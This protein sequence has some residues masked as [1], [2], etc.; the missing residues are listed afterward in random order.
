MALSL[1]E[2][3]DS[4][5]N[6]FEQYKSILNRADADKKELTADDRGN[7]DRLDTQIDA[8]SAEIDTENSDQ[9]R[10][11][12]ATAFEA[13]LRGDIGRQTESLA[14]GS[15]PGVSLPESSLKL[16]RP[17]MFGGVQ[18]EL[19]KFGS[20][21][22]EALRMSADYR[23][24]YMNYLAT[25]ER[26]GLQ[27]GVDTK[28]G[29]LA[30]P[31][32]VAE[33]IKFLDNMVFMRGICR[34][35][36]TPGTV[37]LGVPTWDTDPNDC[38][39]TAEVPASAITEDDAARIG[40]REL[41]PHLLTKL[42]K[43]GMVLLNSNTL[44]SVESLLA[45]RLAY[46]FA[47]TEEQAFL[48]GTGIQQPLGVFTAS[49]S[50]IATTRDTTAAATT[51]FTMDELISTLYSLKA[52][53]QARSTWIFHRDTVQRIRKF[54]TGDSQYLWQ[55]SVV[56][57]QPDLV[58]NRPYVMSEY[59]PNTYTTGLYV[60][61]IGDFSSYWIVDSMNLEIQRLNELY[62]TTNQVGMIGRKMTD[63]MPVLGEAFARLKLA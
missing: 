32:V 53:Y 24:N 2:K 61:I 46:K 1:K 9:K 63:A 23:K 13:R 59:A 36:T 20:G 6:L 30:P 16:L 39:W 38:D 52:A 40:K 35:I 25:G 18:E 27:V 4:R 54:K 58:L 48:T 5:A 31:T 55:P 21:S 41:M 60:A 47:I 19:L 42:L 33:L 3:L 56:A 7:L 26:L 22:P 45:E 17:K 12:K 28:G 62:A 15:A 14:P 49:S 43:M 34:T 50:G 51:T 44:F 10:R 11:E 37:S 29:Y 57:G 8:L